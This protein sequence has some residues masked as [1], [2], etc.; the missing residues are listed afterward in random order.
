MIVTPDLTTVTL[1]GVRL[2]WNKS[3]FQFTN[4]LYDPSSVLLLLCKCISFFNKTDPQQL[5]KNSFPFHHWFS[6]AEIEE[7][8]AI[9]NCLN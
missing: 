8:L 1:T 2:K 3:L 4:C 9:Q 7:V 6:L 5:R